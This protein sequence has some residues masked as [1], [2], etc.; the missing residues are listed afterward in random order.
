MITLIKILVKLIEA[1][2]E[3]V[4]IEQLILKNQ[5]YITVG[6]QVWHEIDENFRISAIVEDKLKSKADEFDKALINKFP[7]LS[8]DD[9]AEL[10]QS[11]AGEV[12]AGKEVVLDNS[13]IIKQLQDSND[14]LTADNSTLKDQLSKVQSF[15]AITTNVAEQATTQA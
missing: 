7:D 10:R 13:T 1:K 11:I 14:Q 15:V 3:K 12:N 2:L 4:G 9:V 8:K 6:K 5:N